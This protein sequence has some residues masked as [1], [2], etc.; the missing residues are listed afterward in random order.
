MYDFQWLQIFADG[1]AGDGGGANGAAQT[2]D[3]AAAA[4][5]QTEETVAD[6]LR[7]KGVPESKLSRRA[8]Q[9]KA[10]Q[11]NAA[12]TPAPK[13]EEG[14][15]AAA[16][17]VAETETAQAAAP[18]PKPSF[19]ELLQQNPE[20]N[21]AVQ[22]IVQ[23]RLSKSKAAEQRMQTLSPALDKLARRYGL[24]DG[25]TAE[26]LAERIDNDD[27]YYEQQAME[28]GVTPE[29]AKQ[30]EEAKVVLAQQRRDEAARQREQEQ[31]QAIR[32]TFDRLHSEI[33]EMQQ[34]FPGFDFEA[35]MRNPQ[36]VFLIQ[37][38]SGLS[39]EQAYLAIHRTEV[40]E[41]ERKATEQRIAATV[42]ANQARPREVTRSQTATD[43]ATT[44]D[45]SKATR[46]QREAL[47]RRIR[48]G[49]RVLPGGGF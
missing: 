4:A 37:P 14:Q 22:Q 11:Q 20:Y 2:G 21:K 25:Y 24:E 34:K 18:E 32:Q 27:T 5:Q 28:L 45:W 38:G 33:G 15:D 7:R 10:P 40:L 8:Y 19:D 3:T 9:Q 41:A 35:E 30:L 6:R 16:E 26:Q 17:P 29:L 43:T 23:K 44:T 48:S 1:A 36:F 31:Q 46:E 49:E 13:A 39:L 42:Q 12:P 47:K